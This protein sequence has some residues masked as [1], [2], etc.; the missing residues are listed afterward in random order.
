VRFMKPTIE[1][2][3]IGPTNEEDDLK[4]DDVRSVK[5]GGVS[6]RIGFLPRIDDAVLRLV[7][8]LTEAEVEF[9]HDSVKELRSKAGMTVSDRVIRQI[10]PAVIA[11]ELK[12]AKR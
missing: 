1:L 2:V 3:H 5:D 11:R 10:A 4:L 8:L 7:V 12:K 9:A 6:K